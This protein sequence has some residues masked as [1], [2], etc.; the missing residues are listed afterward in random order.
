[1][2]ILILGSEGFIGSHCVDHYLAGNHIVYGADLFE[3]SLRQYKYTKIT[4]L[5]PEFDELLRS[6]LFDAVINAAG[7]GN[8]PYSMSHPVSDFEANCLDT[9][10]VLDAIR[11]NQPGCKYIHLSSAAVYGNP[12]GLPIREEDA[13]R[14]LSPYGWH[15]L[16]AEQLCKEY[17]AI[18]NVKTAITRPFSVYG[19]GLKKQL[20]WDLYQKVLNA[21]GAIELFGTGNES[22]DYIHVRDVVRAIDC[23]ITSGDLNGEVYNLASGRETTIAESVGY[24]MSALPD[25]KIQYQFNGKVREGDPLNWRADISRMS[26]LGFTAQ[27]DLQEGLN[28]V[29]AWLQSIN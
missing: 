19:P 12:V 4:R 6:E 10:R 27:H 8:V 15:K 1:M 18:Y 28:E 22:R 13:A 2:K 29:A 24:F 26:R 5:S 3:Q 7:S 17:T 9:I 11:K 14:P 23:V 20:F 16:V 25:K 21:N